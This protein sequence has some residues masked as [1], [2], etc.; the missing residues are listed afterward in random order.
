MIKCPKCESDKI[1][2]GAYSSY[3]EG[4]GSIFCKECDYKFEENFGEDDLLNLN[5]FINKYNKSSN[6]TCE[7][8]DAYL[9]H[10]STGCTCC[11]YENFIEGIFKTIEEA[12][13][14][15]KYHTEHCTVASQ[16]SRTGRYTIYKVKCKKYSNNSRII[17]GHE[18]FDSKNFHENREYYY[19]GEIVK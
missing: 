18:T 4:D 3:S 11:S 16:Y 14:R 7:E 1:F 19:G 8:F 2:V 13:E 9:I 6:I 5:E 17:V 10:G 12:Q 15:K